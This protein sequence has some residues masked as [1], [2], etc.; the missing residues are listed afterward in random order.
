MKKTCNLIF[1][2]LLISSSIKAQ[3]FNE[4]KRA[5]ESFLKR[6]YNNKPFEG[7]RVVDDYDHKYLISVVSLE[8]AKY[9]S[10]SIMNRVAQVKSRQQANTFFNGSSISSELIIHTTEVKSGD[11][12][13]TNTTTEE[14]IKEQSLG[15]VE[16]LEEL[17]RF[18]SQDALKCIIIFIRE[19]EQKNK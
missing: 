14:V 2:F 1:I 7:V 4:D 18:D 6:M 11:N 16:G 12:S 17:T 19:L 15:F 8:K 13:S 5:F 10:E 9:T 3:S